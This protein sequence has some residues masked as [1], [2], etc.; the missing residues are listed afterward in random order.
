MILFAA[1]DRDSEAAG[2]VEAALGRSFTARQIV[3][4]A[5]GEMPISVHGTCA[6]LLNPGE[7]SAAWVAAMAAGGAKILLLGHLAPAI[8]HLLGID[9]GEAL[10]AGAG[11]LDCGAAAPHR[12]AASR[13]RIDYADTGFGAQSPIRRRYLRR[14][15]FA[16][17]W[18]N[19]GYGRIT[20]DGGAWSICHAARPDGAT[21]VA[22]FIVEHESDRITYAALRDLPR[23]ALLWFNREVG[24][25]DS[26]EWRLVETFFSDYRAEALPCR[27]HLREIPLGYDAAV[28]MRLDCD[29]AIGSARPLFEMYRSCGR[30]FSLAVTTG[31]PAGP[32]DLAL[33]REVAASGGSILSHSHSHAAAWGGSCGAALEEAARS[34]AWFET[35]LPGVAVRYAV[36]PFHQTP[37]FALEALWRAGYGGVV[38]G[39]IAGEPQYLI[40]RAGALPFF[41]RPFISHS[42]QCMLHGDCLAG[43]GDP[44]AVYK[45]AF[46]NARRGHSIFAYL[47]HPFSPRYSYG[48][49]SEA[50]RSARHGELLAFFEAESERLLFMSENEC[51]DFIGMRSGCAVVWA[52]D[53]RGFTIEGPSGGRFALA[54]G[55]RGQWRPAERPIVHDGSANDD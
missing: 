41:T 42:Q 44:L 47:D 15:D 24:P 23:A 16:E 54:V 11:W 39:L 50:E 33:L 31:L 27:P 21:S 10:R 2:I 36:S 46:G 7:R 40:S 30:P 4:V 28:T 55:Y 52:A 18:N 13:A 26:Q 17:E 1:E 49:A 53:G 25:V 29:E 48:W 45:A 9:P 8:A 35:R 12:S 3:R 51:L 38:G 37:A 19:L 6:V 43:Q 34:K 14:F 5:A 20:L 32:E 22:E